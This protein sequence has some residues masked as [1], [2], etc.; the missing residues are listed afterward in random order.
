MLFTG[1]DGTK[2]VSIDYSPF[3]KSWKVVTSDGNG[4]KIAVIPSDK[5]LIKTEPIPKGVKKEKQLRKFLSLKYKNFLW[6]VT[7]D[8]Q[9]GTY[10]LVLVKDF[11]PPE[12][13]F[14][15]DAEQFSLTRLANAYGLENVQILDIG[16]RKTTYLNLEG[17]ILK[18]YR[19]VL[20]GGDYITEMVAEELNLSFDEAERLK[21]S[22]GLKNPAVLRAVEEILKNLPLVKEK[23]FLTS[24]GGGK[25]FDSA[26]TPPLP[27][28]VVKVDIP[29]EK[30]YYSALGA[31]LKFAVKDN[32]PSFLQNALSK[33][34]VK[35]ALY[36][37]VILL[38][39][40][41]VSFEVMDQIVDNYYNKLLEREKE[42][43]H[44]KFPQL[45]TVAMVEQLLTLQPKEK[46]SVLPLFKKL[47]EMLPPGVKIF[48][49][50]YSNGIL[51][52]KGEASKEVVNRLKTTYL[53][54][55]GNGR[56]LFELEIK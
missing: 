24:G 55:L 18:S 56:Y 44:K 50:S 25:L 32:S 52:V 30:E 4:R 15:L 36:A 13:V 28:P 22:E 38:L 48:K 35:L 34:K 33:G 37:A 31:A 6:D 23:P 1:I 41:G 2:R 45:P 53:K 29:V 19:V 14:A 3:K 11:K 16:R 54:D 10:T 39:S 40:L 42:L 26:D 17:G 51:K 47:T 5:V 20:K 9:K 49:I 7:M 21:I 12:D 8:F 43:F 46:K 27:A